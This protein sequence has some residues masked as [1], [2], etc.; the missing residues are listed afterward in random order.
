MDARELDFFDVSFDH[1]ACMHV[2]SVVP[3]PPSG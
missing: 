1:V 3:E 2:I